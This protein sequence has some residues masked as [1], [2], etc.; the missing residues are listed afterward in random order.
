MARGLF[1]GL[2]TLDCLYRVDHVPT[3]DEKI[4]AEESL[5]VA[6]GPVTNAAVA[7]RHLGNEAVLLGSVGHHAM[8]S[9][10]RAD[11]ETYGVALV[12]GDPDR[13]DPPPLST[14]LV[15]ATTGDRAVISRNAVG[16][17]IVPP[18]E[19][20]IQAWLT[21]VDIVLIDGHQMALSL[22]IAQQA[23]QQGIPVVVDAGS[24]KPGFDRVLGL[25]TSAIAAERFRPPQCATAAET[26]R[27]L[28]DMGIPE[29]ATT[30]GSQPIQALC[31]TQNQ[32]PLETDILV[33]TFPVVDTLG[34][35]D[36]LH[37]AFC[38]FRLRTSPLPSAPSEDP[39]APPSTYP[40]TPPPFIAALTQAAA[41]ASHSCQ[42]FG[43]RAW[44]QSAP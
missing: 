7:F 36:I 32:H 1:V 14:I 20:A 18:P 17:Q 15:T 25:A 13:Q 44:L 38:H 21:G 41:V 11:L 30:H 28:L 37:G 3:S 5:L 29:V 23:R 43:T 33:P 6:G 4:V 10:I 2:I 26:R 22:A 42:F 19:A 16:H 40:A 27:A 39:F 31:H 24:W 12:D 9:L 35:G 8:T 34:A